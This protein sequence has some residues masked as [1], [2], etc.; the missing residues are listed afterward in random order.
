MNI[1]PIAFSFDNNLVFPA[2]VCI[3]SLLISAEENTFYDI[4]I[5]HS[6]N[7][8]FDREK[9][10][11]LLKFYKRCRI[12]YRLV[13]NTFDDAFEIRGITT[14]TY[15]R[16][17]IPE[18]VT[19]YDKIIY[20]DVDVIFRSD[21]FEVYNNTDLSDA[22][23]AGVNAIIPLVP[24]MRKYYEGIK[25]IDINKIIYAGNII[26]NSK[27][28][29]E[30]K[31]VERFKS[32]SK[33]KY[34]FQDLD[35]LNIACK[36]K[37]TYLNPEFCLTTYI[38]D[39]AVNKRSLLYDYWDD[40]KISE[41]LSKGIVHYNGQ[42]PWKGFCVNFDIWWE[43]YRKSPFFDEK[44]YF[45]FFYSRLNELDQLSLWKRIK[46]IVR[47]FVYGKREI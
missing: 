35:I 23:V 42:K 15:N 17:L 21:L 8:L 12:Q 19:E 33:N 1:V 39:L 43:Y 29:R 11:G 18:I 5:L 6:D 38:M 34:R 32:L 30:D 27:K 3:S 28:I 10:D 41:A 40:I 7:E 14:S 45:E 46:I 13:D 24:D 47:Y 36:G 4:F 16:L 9:L 2:C 44:F 22:Y 20:S 26:F 31:V 25:G 37:I